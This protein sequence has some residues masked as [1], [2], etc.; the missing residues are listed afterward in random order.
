M[1]LYVQAQR[2]G[3]LVIT[4]VI[5]VVFLVMMVA[6][7]GLVNRQFHEIVGQE[8]EEQAFQISEAGVSY[9]LWLLD[10]DLV[11]YK[12]PQG[13]T[14]YQVIDET[15][16]PKEVLGTF[17]LTFETLSFVE[18]IGPATIKVKSIGEDAVLT[19]RKQTI[20]AVIQS[21]SDPEDPA[22]Q[23]EVWRVIEWDH[24]P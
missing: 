18:P 9:A 22:D 2:G 20:E 10:N 4:L 3:V 17:D 6:T 8:Q 13:V 11:D 7:V 12:S 15:K 23:L 19:K 1:R 14:D 16:E 24:K 5:L 21:D